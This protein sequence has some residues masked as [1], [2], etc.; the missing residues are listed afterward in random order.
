M[1]STF[2]DS[3]AFGPMWSLVAV[4]YV[5]TASVCLYT[6]QSLWA[7]KDQCAYVQSLG[8]WDKTVYL[9]A[10]ALIGATLAV[11]P[12]INLVALLL[13]LGS[14]LVGWFHERQARKAQKAYLDRVLQAA[15]QRG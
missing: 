12:Y 5:L 2:H 10:N 7:T 13:T 15:V 6:W 1:F 4:L 14:I 9:L 8:R 11:L 3:M